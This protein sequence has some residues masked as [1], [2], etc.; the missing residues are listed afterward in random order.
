[1]MDTGLAMGAFER[2]DEVNAMAESAAKQQMLSNLAGHVLSCWSEAKTEKT[3][4]HERLL[5]CQRA[6]AGVYD[7]DMQSRINA[8]GGTDLFV[9]LTDIKCRA[10]ESWIKDIML[11]SDD[12]PATLSPT[13]V[14][15]LPPEVVTE[16]MAQLQQEAV[17][18][19]MTQ[20]TPVTPEQVAERM[21]SLAEAAGERIQK[22]AQ[23]RAEK[24]TRKIKDQLVEGGWREAFA[25]AVH[26]LC[27]FPNAF[28]KGPVQRRRKTVSF[29]PT[30]EMVVEEK[31]RQEFERVSPFDIYPSPGA[32]SVN[33][34]Y[35]I[36][37]LSLPRGELEAMIGVPGYD[38]EAIREVL[39]DMPIGGLT[40]VEP[41]DSE[42]RVLENRDNGIVAS[43]VGAGNIEAI[44]FHGRCTGQML[45]DWGMTEDLDPILSYEAEVWVVKNT[46]I[47]AV[48]NPDP[49][50]RRNYYKTGWQEVPGAFW[51]RALPEMMDDVQR[52]VNAASRAMVDN[53]SL[54]SGP[55]VG[56]DVSRLP[57]GAKIT[58]L[59][60]WQVHQFTSSQ[61]SQS[62]Q[63]PIMFF[64][65]QSNVN[66]LNG[67]RKEW[68]QLADEVTG[69][70]NYT[71]GSGNV[72]GAGR[73]SSGLSM[74]M[75]NAS[76]GI[77]QVI[78]NIDL[79]VIEPVITRQYE[80]NML[81]D[82]DM[83][84]KGDC[85]VFARG[86]NSLV[87]KE[88]QQ[89][90]RNE[91]LGMLLQSPVAQQI[92]GV[93]GIANL[94]REVVKTLDMPADDIIPD[95]ESARQKAVQA[96]AQML[97]QQMLQ[98]MAAE[99]GMVA[100]AG[101]GAPTQ[102]PMGVSVADAQ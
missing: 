43:S 5:A 58:T 25:G 64:Q 93:E 26:D 67:V 47:R 32:V 54:A 36:E 3:Q 52:V 23:K 71:Y 10:A 13:P 21:N 34:G 66:E 89:L 73:T 91:F 1:M 82:P 49:L 20:A 96:Q 86:A 65:P 44:A 12:F 28:I 92:A 55:Q 80:H 56:V 101:G 16:I 68:T 57:A 29:S 7:A 30:G 81:Y 83:S 60:P 59:R 39:M 19:A 46:A 17:E 38:G 94:M 40:S 74:L 33:D 31:I 77:K 41:G 75:A 27:T 18:T 102:Q 24:M 14:A 35:L 48:L 69:V 11:P 15:E 70:P 4:V 53:M 50:G 87:I 85:K 62:G 22:E 76:K 51:W 99:K 45:L 63:A 88:Q 84:I 37:R 98:Q 2:Q 95:E 72:G 8:M 79:G 9:R 90:R 100:A 97:A 78:A 6:R 61:F 42:R